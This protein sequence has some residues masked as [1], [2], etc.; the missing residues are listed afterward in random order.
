MFTLKSEDFGQKIEV[1]STPI[2]AIANDLLA[3]KHYL[4]KNLILYI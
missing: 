3:L 2:C 4:K 1:L